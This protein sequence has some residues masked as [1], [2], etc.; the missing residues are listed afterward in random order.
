[1]GRLMRP[2]HRM[3]TM[4]DATQTPATSVSIVYRKPLRKS[5]GRAANSR[6]CCADLLR[7]PSE[8]GALRRLGIDCDI[9]AAPGV[10]LHAV[11]SVREPEKVLSLALI[12]FPDKATRCVGSRIVPGLQRSVS[13]AGPHRVL[14]GLIV[15]TSCLFERSRYQVEFLYSCQTWG[16]ARAETS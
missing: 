3:S 4:S 1:M 5:R 10:V 11:A 2:A 12:E 8:L 15:S 7:E 14:Q 16:C 9:R 6:S 13:D